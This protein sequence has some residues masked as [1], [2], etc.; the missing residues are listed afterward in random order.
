MLDYQMNGEQSPLLNRFP[1]RLIVPGWYST[2]WVKTLNNVEVLN[3]PDENYRMETVY[4]IPDTPYASVKP[5]E[6]AFRT[7]PI[8]RMVPRSFFTNVSNNTIVKP[9]APVPV[10]GIA[11]GGDCGVSQVELSVDGGRSCRKTA[12][13]HDEGTYSFRQWSTQITAPQSGS[14]TQDA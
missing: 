8:N 7:V 6:S 12:L 1:L 5:R 3:A 4:R 10:R 11:V 2:H 9:A 13:G 14:R